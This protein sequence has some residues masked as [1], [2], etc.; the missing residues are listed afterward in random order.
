M[1]EESIKKISS[2]TPVLFLTGRQDELVPPSHMDTLMKNCSSGIKI[3]MV[4]HHGNHNDTCIQ[5]GYFESIGLFLS[6]YII[7]LTSGG[8]GAAQAAQSTVSDKYKF[9]QN[10]TDGI[11][12]IVVKQKDVDSSAQT[13]SIARQRQPYTSTADSDENEWVEMSGSIAPQDAVKQKL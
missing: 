3:R 4:L 12:D 11:I 6:R 9:V 2:Q 8:E 13:T 7:P 5:P 1:S 10:S